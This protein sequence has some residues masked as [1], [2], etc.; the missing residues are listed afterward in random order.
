[1][2]LPINLLS[3]LFKGS[4]NLRLH[5]WHDGVHRHSTV[6]YNSRPTDVWSAFV[7]FLMGQC[8]VTSVLCE[9]VSSCHKARQMH[10]SNAF[11]SPPVFELHEEGQ[12]FANCSGQTSWPMGHGSVDVLLFLCFRLV[13]WKF[14]L[15]PGRNGCLYVG[16]QMAPLR[17]RITGQFVR[18]CGHLA[19]HPVHLA[20]A[21]EQATEASTDHGD[22][23]PVHAMSYA[24]QRSGHPCWQF[25]HQ[26][27]H[28]EF[29]AVLNYHHYHSNI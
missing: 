12:P 17:H 6:H 26:Q 9:K 25:H 3:Y 27:D 28:R 7:L 2:F 18:W 22:R 16:L 29:G 13:A 21:W 1:M 4:R 10:S 8:S 11:D 23:S 20:G 19:A 14:S 24:V 5:V 15:F